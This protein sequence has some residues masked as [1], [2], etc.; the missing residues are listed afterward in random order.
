MKT[1]N[2]FENHNHFKRIFLFL[3]LIDFLLLLISCSHKEPQ[4]KFQYFEQSQVDLLFQNAVKIEPKGELIT[5]QSIYVDSISKTTM[6]ITRNIQNYL[7]YMAVDDKNQIVSKSKATQGQINYGGRLGP[8][9]AQGGCEFSC[10]S[11]GGQL[12][13]L[14][15]GTSGCLSDG[16]GGC[17]SST[18]GEG[19]VNSSPCKSFNQGY[20]FMA[21][22]SLALLQL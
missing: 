5:K 14:C 11:V 16:F 20:A 3:I 12:G 19:C 10:R 8:I 17:S 9:F 21:D 1:S 13:R 4:K 6:V 7:L 22:L 2:L 15:P 18:C